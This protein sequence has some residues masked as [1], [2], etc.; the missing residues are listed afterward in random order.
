MIP[1]YHKPRHDYCMCAMKILLLPLVFLLVSFNCAKAT[2][3]QKVKLTKD[4][5]FTIPASVGDP[6][7]LVQAGTDVKLVKVVG[8]K[9]HL[10]HGVAEAMVSPECTD[11]DKELISKWQESKTARLALASTLEAE[12]KAAADDLERQGISLLMGK[13]FQSV[14]TGLIVSVGN[15][16]FVLLR[17]APYQPEGSAVECLAKDAREMFTYQTVGKAEKSIPVFKWQ[18][19]AD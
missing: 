18:P 15:G 12:R 2:L 13:V 8:E 9:L 16:S 11:V 6:E 4:V 3:P 17:G 7:V 14:G 5:A 1:I 19:S 10:E